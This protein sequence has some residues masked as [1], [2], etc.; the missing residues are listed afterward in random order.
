MWSSEGHGFPA[1]V[2]A[3]LTIPLAA[4]RR[5]VHP[6]LYALLSLS[7]VAMQYTPSLSHEDQSCTRAN[8]DNLRI[9]V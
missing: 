7:L 5:K 3:K 4:G 6:G 9:A 1:I 2:P 8:A